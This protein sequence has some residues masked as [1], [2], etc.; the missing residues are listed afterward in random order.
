MSGFFDIKSEADWE[1]LKQDI[2]LESLGGQHIVSMFSDSETTRSAH[3]ISA[4]EVEKLNQLKQLLVEK[5]GEDSHPQEIL[6]AIT[7]SPIVV[8]DMANTWLYSLLTSLNKLRLCPRPKRYRWLLGMNLAAIALC[9]DYLV[10]C[11]SQGVDTSHLTIRA[12]A[13]PNNEVT[14]E[15]IISASTSALNMSMAASYDDS[16]TNTYEANYER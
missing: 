7:T 1:A 12:I 5:I 6:T 8:A 14:S 3:N 4:I 16:Q 10:Q 9:K 15:K 11:K 13:V 2:K